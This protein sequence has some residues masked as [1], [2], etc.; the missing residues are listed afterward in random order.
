MPFRTLPWRRRPDPKPRAAAALVPAGQ[1][2]YAI[3]DIHGRVDLLD[4]LLEQIQA[5]ATRD[6]TL[7]NT[8]IFLG[9]YVDR[10]LDSAPVLERL[11]QGPPPGFGAIHLLGNHEETVLQFLRDAEA[12]ARWLKFGGQATLLSY[13]IRRPPGLAEAAWLF[14]AQQELRRT[15]PPTHLAFLRR[16]RRY[17]T[18]GGYLFVHAGIRPNV[19]LDAQEN[20]DLLWIRDDFLTSKEDHG[21]VVVHGHSIT[22]EPDERPNRIGIDTGAYASG[23]LTALVLEGAERRYLTT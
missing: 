19:P 11:S 22:D 17:V 21:W 16:L 5:D 13:G 20:D 9:D 18:V 2:L 14:H 23:R 12:G 4:R 15:L 10:G 7:S 8:L 1:R 6:P 3:G